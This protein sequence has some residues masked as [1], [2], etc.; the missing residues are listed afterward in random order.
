MIS[1]GVVKD[2]NP[3]E[4]CVL[5]TWL[6]G[7]DHMH[8]PNR[9]VIRRLNLAPSGKIPHMVFTRKKKKNS[10]TYMEKEQRPLSNGEGQARQFFVHQ[11]AILQGRFM[12]GISQI[13]IMS[14]LILRRGVSM[15]MDRTVGPFLGAQ[16]AN[17]V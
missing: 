9:F 8:K 2:G 1:K 4:G 6:T 12:L 11:V 15:S 10:H 16:K 3:C 5:L 14:S 13:S 7:F 17:N